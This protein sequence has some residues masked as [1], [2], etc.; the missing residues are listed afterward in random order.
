MNK[1]NKKIIAYRSFHLVGKLGKKQG[2][3]NIM[4]WKMVMCTKEKNKRGFRR[5]LGSWIKENTGFAK[6]NRT[7]R[8]D[9]IEK[10]TFY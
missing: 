9:F 6:L 10:V 4:V 3:V 7:V 8:E 2:I 5:R 1:T